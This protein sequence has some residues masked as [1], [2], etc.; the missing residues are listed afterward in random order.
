[1]DNESVNINDVNQWK[2][3]FNRPTE[4]SIILK[5]AIVK[6]DYSIIQQNKEIES[7]LKEIAFDLFTKNIVYKTYKI[8]FYKITFK[9]IAVEENI[10]LNYILS[11]LNIKNKEDIKKMFL[12][13]T[14]IYTHSIIIDESFKNSDI[15]II[16][17]PYTI[18]KSQEEAI[19][20]Y[21]N[22]YSKLNEMIY[23][24]IV[25][26]VNEFTDF[27]NASIVFADKL[28]NFF[29]PKEFIS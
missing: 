18:N 7:E 27:L 26:L 2:Q 25:S 12:Y 8:G 23:I 22:F 9:S 6:N 14:A 16:P 29:Y 15:N 10:M 24:K 17:P 13:P 19:E 20:L 4:K 28:I 3:I 5:E 21:V 11:Q 1:M